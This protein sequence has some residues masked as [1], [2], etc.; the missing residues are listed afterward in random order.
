ME[1]TS[2]LSDAFFAFGPKREL[3]YFG[4]IVGGKPLPYRLDQFLDSGLGR[5]DSGDVAGT[6]GRLANARIWSWAFES[7]SNRTRLAGPQHMI[8]VSTPV[9][10]ELDSA[11]VRL[12][13]ILEKWLV[14]ISYREEWVQFQ[15]R[16][17]EQ[18]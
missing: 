15:T 3:M 18:K 17:D 4:A 2:F 9:S 14:P 11:E 10:K 5:K 7:F 13:E 12:K 1:F 6:V 16:S 8:R